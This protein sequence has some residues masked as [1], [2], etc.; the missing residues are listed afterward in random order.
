MTYG[1]VKKWTTGI[2]YVE[3]GKRDM[4][5]IGQAMRLLAGCQSWSK[6]KNITDLFAIATHRF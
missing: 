4:G 5:R 1:V 6:E 3:I 2:C